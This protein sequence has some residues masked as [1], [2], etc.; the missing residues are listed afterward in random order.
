MKKIKLKVY[1]TASAERI[2][3][4]T[5]PGVVFCSMHALTEVDTL[6]QADIVVIGGTFDVPPDT[7]STPGS[8]PWG[9]V[10]ILVTS[11]VEVWFLRNYNGNG[12][13]EIKIEVL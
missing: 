12:K 5:M 9:Y 7:H 4:Q 1:F 6:H 8:D 11:K 13:K 2:L 10:N 3:F